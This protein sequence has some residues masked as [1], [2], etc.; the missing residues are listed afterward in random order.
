MSD[1]EKLLQALRIIDEIDTWV[2]CL[3]ADGKISE[4]DG[5]EILT[6]C[7]KANSLL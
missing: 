3:F 2:R 7:K 1:K 4:Q 5:N 6:Y